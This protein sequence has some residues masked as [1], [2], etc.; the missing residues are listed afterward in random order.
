MLSKIQNLFGW[1]TQYAYTDYRKYTSWVAKRYSQLPEFR[2]LIGPRAAHG[3]NVA[4]EFC[5]NNKELI[6]GTLTVGCIT[7]VAMKCL[8]KCRSLPQPKQ[9]K[10]S[11]PQTLVPVK[12]PT[13]VPKQISSPI[14][15]SPAPNVTFS[16]TINLGRLYIKIPKGE[17]LPPN[18]SLTFCVDTSSSMRG[19]RE[20][21]LKKAVEDVLVHAQGIVDHSKGATIE[22]AIV[23]FNGSASII[24]APIK[25][26]PTDSK[27]RA[28]DK[29]IANLKRLNSSGG[30]RI[31][32]GLG[33]ATDQ[34]ERM[35]KQNQHGNHTLILLTDGD[36]TLNQGEVETIHTR[37]KKAHANLFAVGIGKGHKQATLETIAPR[38]GKFTGKYINT[39]AGAE[40]IT[41]AISGIYK[42]A[43]SA[44]H[45]V[46]LKSSQLEAGT[47]S[48]D[49]TA[50]IKGKKGSK[51]KLGAIPEEKPTSG[52]IQ[53]HGDRLKGPL[54]LSTL[55]FDLIIKGPNGEKRN[56]ALPWKPN[57]T[58]DPKLI[59]EGRQF[60]K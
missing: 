51:C 27:Q 9:L 57:T 21:E 52:F 14:S 53:I 26:T 34:L 25:I 43:I 6:F 40:T 36:D 47:W 3:L 13:V 19:E 22:I 35:S 28:I 38:D 30:T 39:A 31:L 55:S 32:A 50:S 2:T 42:R 56:I 15:K 18:V 17:P 1:D 33:A 41:S 12:G 11:A 60:V 7:L 59:T 23:G 8:C 16:T 44:S 24:S 4:K 48:I 46:K 49:Y 37:L 54:E 29:I 58:I 45:N 5:W 10:A 20:T